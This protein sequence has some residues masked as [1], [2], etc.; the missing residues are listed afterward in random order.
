[1]FSCPSVH[2][3]A[4]LQDFLS[5]TPTCVQELFCLLQPAVRLFCSRRASDLPVDI[6]EEVLDETLL[7]LKTRDRARFN[8]VHGTIEGYLFNS[9]RSALKNVR[10]KYSRNRIRLQSGDTAYEHDL[11]PLDEMN[12]SD[13]RLSEHRLHLAIRA[14]QVLA[15]ADAAMRDVI[16]RIY[17]AGEDRKSALREIGLDR[18]AFLRQCRR[19]GREINQLNRC[20]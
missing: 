2:L 10:S 8:P 11:V 17:F 5:E 7:L 13:C 20:A 19:I 12:L 4:L 15:H 9:F 18:F 16:E 6:R 1:M 3:E 14:D